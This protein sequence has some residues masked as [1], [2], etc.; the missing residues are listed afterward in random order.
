MIQDW[1][2]SVEMQESQAFPVKSSLIY[3]SAFEFD[4]LFTMSLLKQTPD[5]PQCW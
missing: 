1:L 3:V 2:I 5:V 4:V